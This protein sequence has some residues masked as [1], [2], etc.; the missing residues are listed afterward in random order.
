MTNPNLI[1]GTW[2]G[3]WT[4]ITSAGTSFAFAATLGIFVFEADGNVRGEFRFKDGTAYNVRPFTGAYEVEL[5]PTNDV[6]TGKATVT[7]TATGNVNTLS[8]VRV[9]SDEIAHVLE[10]AAKSDGTPRTL[11]THGTLHRVRKQ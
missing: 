3:T 4:N 1:V 7:I 10:S 5:D 9:N 11:M 8:F 6:F 2:V